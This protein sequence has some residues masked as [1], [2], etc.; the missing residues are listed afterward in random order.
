MLNSV[1]RG[2]KS[3]MTAATETIT[4]VT[5]F[6]MCIVLFHIY[7]QLESKLLVGNKGGVPG[8]EVL[9]DEDTFVDYYSNRARSVKCHRKRHTVPSTVYMDSQREFLRYSLEGIEDDFV[10]YH[11]GRYRRPIPLVDF[12]IEEYQSWLS[13]LYID[14]SIHQRVYVHCATKTHLIWV[15]VSDRFLDTHIHVVIVALKNWKKVVSFYRKKIIPYNVEFSSSSVAGCTRFESRDLSWS[16]AEIQISSNLT[17]CYEP[18][19]KLKAKDK[20]LVAK[21]YMANSLRANDGKWSVTGSLTN[22]NISFALGVSRSHESV[23]SVVPLNGIYPRYVHL[24]CGNH[25]EIKIERNGEEIARDEGLSC[26]DWGKAVET[27]RQDIE[28]TCMT[29]NGVAAIETEHR[30]SPD[31][32]DNHFALLTDTERVGVSLCNG[33]VYNQVALHNGIWV[34]SH[35]FPLSQAHFRQAKNAF[36]NEIWQIK[37]L[38]IST[39]EEG[40]KAGKETNF[41][42]DF[43]PRL[44]EDSK[45]AF[46]VVNGSIEYIDNHEHKRVV[47]R[48]L[49]G[50]LLVNTD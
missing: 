19:Q 21:D 40:K 37:Q 11:W 13:S 41:V 43:R 47:I 20:R 35:F 2:A 30:V 8:M 38:P 45:R 15:A 4:F 33:N 28:N 25:G 5:V 18:S 34:E 1:G 50:S 22:D 39:M 9:S 26:F 44:N 31:P 49:V 10:K 3:K 36:D 12:H 6:C 7:E 42:L 24:E 46:G 48:D 29:F 14:L 17:I 27:S 32:N 23:V 16:T